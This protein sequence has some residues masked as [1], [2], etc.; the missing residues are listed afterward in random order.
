MA[1]IGDPELSRVRP[2]PNT[3][4]KPCEEP[5]CD[6]RTNIRFDP[7]EGPRI[8]ACCQEHGQ[9][10]YRRRLAGAPCPR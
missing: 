8:T 7:L 6:I 10:V 4:L 2:K 1:T 9:R 5:E 3:R